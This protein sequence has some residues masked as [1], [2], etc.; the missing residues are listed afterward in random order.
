MRTSSVNCQSL[1][2]GDFE[3]HKELNNLKRDVQKKVAVK[4]QLSVWKKIMRQKANR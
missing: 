1:D 4:V 3:I 2:H